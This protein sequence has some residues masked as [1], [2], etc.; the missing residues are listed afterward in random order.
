MFTGRSLAT[1]VPYVSTILVS[2]AMSQYQWDGKGIWK[3]RQM[4]MKA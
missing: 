4:E 2:A 3:K 1:A